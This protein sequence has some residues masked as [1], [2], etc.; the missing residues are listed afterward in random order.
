MTLVLSVADYDEL[1]QETSSRQPMHPSCFN[2]GETHRWLPS[3]L[4]RGSTYGIELLSGIWLDFIDKEFTQSWALKVPS[5]EHLVQITVL[6]SGVV[7]YDVVYPALRAGQSY[8]SG[9]GI[10]PGYTAKYGRSRQL[11]GINI[12]FSPEAVEPLLTEESS[13][14]RHLLLKA[15]D[16]KTAWFPPVTPQIRAVV[17]QMMQC[18]L[19][20][21]ARRF[22]LQ[23]KVFELLALQLDAVSTELKPSSATSSLKPQTVEC[24]YQ[25]KAILTNQLEQ[26][27]SITELSAQ[28]GV[29]DRTLRRGFHQ[30]FGTSVIGYLKQQRMIQAE[31]LLR[32]NQYTVAEVA[33]KVGY[34]H[35]GHFAAAF[36]QQFGITPS[37]CIN[38]SLCRTRRLV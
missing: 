16:W 2:M 5:H 9:S 27:P 26:P 3:A 23:A 17:Q 22:Y 12:H 7:D 37:E 19:Q 24:I 18:P 29:C 10:S 38:G 20:N 32:Q 21:S 8:F 34:T 33:N 35:L 25:A 6:L 1:S 13:A 36:K 4:G 11:K 15:D 31:Q 14:L 28:V 30:L